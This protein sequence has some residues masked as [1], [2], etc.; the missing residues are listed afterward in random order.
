M[1]A[2]VQIITST[3]ELPRE[4]IAFKMDEWPNDS[5]IEGYTEHHHRASGATPDG[6]FYR[7]VSAASVLT[8]LRAEDFFIEFQ[9]RCASHPLLVAAE[10]GRLS[11]AHRRAILIGGFRDIRF[12]LDWLAIRVGV[13]LHPKRLQG[14]TLPELSVCGSGDT[15]PNIW[16]SDYQA[17]FGFAQSVLTW[18]SLIRGI[19]CL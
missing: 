17:F 9:A 7:Y 15:E 12:D 10:A 18:G 3:W 2:D 4:L 1:R 14:A 13:P 11:L 8:H 6:T 16:Y 5:S 19:I